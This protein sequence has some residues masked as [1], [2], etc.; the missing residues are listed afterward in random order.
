MG[1]TASNAKNAK[2]SVPA[3]KERPNWRGFCNIDLSDD[4]VERISSDG[5]DEGDAFQ[6]LLVFASDAYK[7]T[8]SEDFA[9]G[10]VIVSLTGKD[11]SGSNE[12]L[13][14]SSRGPDLI[15][16]IQVAYYKDHVLAQDGSWEA[17][18]SSSVRSKFG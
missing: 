1:A 8:I 7:I 10:C 14:L 15:R 5:F 6:A 13:T 3:K 18:E 11:G 4:D 17:V 2:K 9:H 16:A 12:G